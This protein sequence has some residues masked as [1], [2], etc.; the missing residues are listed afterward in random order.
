MGLFGPLVCPVRRTIVRTSPNLAYFF[1]SHSSK[2]KNRGGAIHM[3]PICFAA[4]LSVILSV[5]LSVIPSNQFPWLFFVVLG[6]IDLKCD[7]NLPFMVKQKNFGLCRVWTNLVWVIHCVPRAPVRKVSSRLYLFAYCSN[8]YN[9]M[10]FTR[11]RRHFVHFGLVA[12]T[13]IVVEYFSW[14]T[15]D[16]KMNLFKFIKF[17]AIDVTGNAVVCVVTSYTITSLINVNNQQF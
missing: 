14:N 16:F 9:T 17:S 13:I 4:S 12:I 2:K 8:A 11:V 7:M 1:K 5:R 6:D 15:M 10:H 3:F